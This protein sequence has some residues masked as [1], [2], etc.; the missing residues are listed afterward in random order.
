MTEKAVVTVK[1]ASFL[2]SVI[3]LEKLHKAISKEQKTALETLV[4]L[5]KDTKDEGRKERIAIKLLELQVSIAEKISADQ[6]N[7]LIAEFKL[8]GNP[9]GKLVE[10]PAQGK[11]RAPIVDFSTVRTPE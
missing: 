2:D 8:S 1:D 4:T 10:L 11:P 9:T 5:L 3:D 7:R 6:L